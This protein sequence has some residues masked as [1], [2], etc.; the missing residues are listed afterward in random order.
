MSTYYYNLDA[1]DSDENKAWD[2]MQSHMKAFYMPDAIVFMDIPEEVAYERVVK[3]NR[4]PLRKM[5][6]VDEMKTDK[7]RLQNYLAKM[8]TST[9]PKL[10]RRVLLL[11][12]FRLLS[13]SL[14]L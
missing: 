6:E 2:M 5:D 10:V 7:I 12:P 14:F 9:S 4:G 8:P 3:R 11:C 13:V 1:Y